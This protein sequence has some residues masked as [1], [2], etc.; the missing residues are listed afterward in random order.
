MTMTR[1]KH[2]C[3]ESNQFR[4]IDDGCIMVTAILSRP[5]T[6]G[7]ESCVGI[8]QTGDSGENEPYSCILIH[9]YMETWVSLLSSSRRPENKEQLQ[10]HAT[11]QPGT[12]FLGAYYDTRCSMP[13]SVNMLGALGL[14]PEVLKLSST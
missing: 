4:E 12:G 14:K 10:K 1:A 13:T 5:K 11:E 8:Y 3:V 2:H 7:F 6:H 9:V